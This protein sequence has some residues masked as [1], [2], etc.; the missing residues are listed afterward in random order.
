VITT[1]SPEQE[2]WGALNS[3]CTP[4]VPNVIESS[5]QRGWAIEPGRLVVPEIAAVLT[6]LCGCGAEDK[7]KATRGILDHRVLQIESFERNVAACAVGLM[8]SR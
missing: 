8:Y 3:Y 5:A 7:R 6:I 1:V 4:V 2:L